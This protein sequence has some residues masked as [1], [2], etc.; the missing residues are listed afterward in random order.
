MSGRERVGERERG[1]EKREMK[2][3]GG[4]E[5]GRQSNDRREGEHERGGA[6]REKDEGRGRE[7]G[8]EGGRLYRILPTNCMSSQLYPLHCL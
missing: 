6:R 2:G 5:R 4:R 1:G 7:E 3:E 8:R